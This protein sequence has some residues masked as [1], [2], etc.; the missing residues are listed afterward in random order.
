MSLV[1][2]YPLD[3][4]LKDYSGNKLDLVG[5]PEWA[6]NGINGKCFKNSGNRMLV[7][8]QKITK[9][10]NSKN[11]TVSL[12]WNQLEQEP[13]KEWKDALTF[14]IW[15]IE[16][17]YESQYSPSS[18]S[19]IHYNDKI[20]DTSLSYNLS[21][22]VSNAEWFLYTMVRRN[23]KFMVYINDKLLGSKDILPTQLKQ[24]TEETYFNVST[25]H[26]PSDR[27][28]DIRIYDHGLSDTEIKALYESTKPDSRVLSNICKD[29][30]N[31]NYD[32]Y[33]M[34]QE[35]KPF[36]IFDFTSKID[37]IVSDIVDIKNGNIIKASDFT[38]RYGYKWKSLIIPKIIK[39]NN[40]YSE[41]YKY[42]RGNKWVKLN[43][44]MVNTNYYIQL[45][46]NGKLLN[47][48]SCYITHKNNNL[49]IKTESLDGINITDIKMVMQNFVVKYNSVKYDTSESNITYSINNVNESYISEI[50]VDSKLYKT[51]T[52]VSVTVAEPHST[53]DIYTCKTII[54]SKTL[55]NDKIIEINESMISKD[56]KGTKLEVWSKSWNKHDGNHTKF[57]LNDIV[58][59]KFDGGGTNIWIL[60]ENLQPY[61][62]ARFDTL[63]TYSNHSFIHNYNLSI[64]YKISST[65]KIF[66]AYSEYLDSIPDNHIV[67]ISLFD[68]TIMYPEYLY[69]KLVKYFNVSTPR[70]DIT[71]RDAWYMI[72]EKNSEKFIEEYNG[73]EESVISGILYLN[74]RTHTPLSGKAM[75]YFN[76]NGEFYIPNEFIKYAYDNTYK[77]DNPITGDIIVHKYTDL[78]GDL[79]DNDYKTIVDR[80][81]NYNNY[82]TNYLADTLP[83]FIK[84]FK[85]FKISNIDTELMKDLIDHNPENYKTYL[86]QT[87]KPKFSFKYINILEDW[88]NHTDNIKG[89]EFQM[90]YKSYLDNPR[91]MLIIR[92]PSIQPVIV[93][94]NG[95][96]ITDYDTYTHSNGYQFLFINTSTLVE[97]LDVESVFEVEILQD[98]GKH[99]VTKVARYDN[100]IHIEFDYLDY[101]TFANYTFYLNGKRIHTDYIRVA[102]S[103]GETHVNATYI[104][105]NIP[106]KKGDIMEVVNMSH[107]P[108]MIYKLDDFPD[109]GYISVDKDLLRYPLSSKYYDIFINGRKMSIFDEHFISDN[110]IQITKSK[111]KNRFEL[112]ERVIG[113][114]SFNLEYNRAINEWDLFIDSEVLDKYLLSYDITDIES[115]KI[116][117]ITYNN[118]SSQY[119]LL[120]KEMLNNP[121]ELR[122]SGNNRSDRVNFINE[123]MN[124]LV[125]GDSSVKGIRISTRDPQLIPMRIQRKILDINNKPEFED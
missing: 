39:Y 48:D 97:P 37:D 83:D 125:E 86:D 67:I 10:F 34:V 40:M 100:D 9:A 85:E 19:P 6:N 66:E 94:H 21:H 102:N 46:I 4:D 108:S 35:A 57:L 74:P 81:S 53:V 5:V 120:M 58:F 79:T 111:S 29:A 92:N 60:D 22:Y 106:I 87:M 84:N 115:D 121:D 20:G 91:L 1:A 13:I 38:Y 32:K 54:D 17:G 88:K 69:N 95:L 105:F 119:Y 90:D 118:K 103:K 3:G 24:Y 52:D 93:Y 28:N 42:T 109:N 23:G 59:G 8:D 18:Y 76:S 73:T 36:E 72:S 117:E 78:S 82:N 89:I 16:R 104:L 99:E 44:F 47:S 77:L 98:G 123:N 50:Y 116:G 62:Y 75:K 7:R 30:I 114:E 113:S 15:R 25:E 26:I 49:I 41:L 71:Y 55:D 63:H 43:D 110:K 112:Y 80:Y 14:G 70:T 65:K 27:Y 107:I 31:H 61:E 12:W 33:M 56:G 124:L 11:M 122:I 51:S 68:A 96:L 101:I 64:K 45:F 2:W